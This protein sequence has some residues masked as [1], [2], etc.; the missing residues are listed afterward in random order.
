MQNG[1]EIAVIGMAGKFPGADNVDAF[2][3]N[4]KNGVES[5]TFFSDEEL[6][7]NG[8]SKADISN[9]SYI[10]A[11]SY[12]QGKEYF[13]NDFFGYRPDEARLMDPQ[14]RI[15]HEVVWH[16]FEDAGYDISKYAGRVGLFTG[17]TSNVNWEAYSIIV[18]EAQQ[19]VDDFSASSLRNIDYNNSRISYLLNLKGP[20]LALN[21]ACS[22]SLVAIHQACNSLLLGECS[23][24]VA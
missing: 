8:V 3:S 6:L 24:A 4:L 22:T 9:P 23:M 19:L 14:M 21:T 18:N 5:I 15:M 10:K 1:L 17:A 12:V 7:R 2:W 11:G 20:S 16:A 13:D